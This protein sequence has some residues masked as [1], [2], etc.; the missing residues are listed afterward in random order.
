MKA[1]HETASKQFANNSDFAVSEETVKKMSELGSVEAF[2]LSNFHSN[3]TVQDWDKK[4]ILLF[5]TFIL[6]LIWNNIRQIYVI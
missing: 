6:Q 3:A 5:S 2:S 4:V 1:L